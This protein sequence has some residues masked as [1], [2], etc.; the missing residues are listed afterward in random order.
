MEIKSL[1]NL[2][3]QNCLVTGG[4]G[5]LGKQ[6]IEAFAELGANIITLDLK[7]LII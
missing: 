3:N 1:I 4:F 5:Y 7:A 2:K 6:I